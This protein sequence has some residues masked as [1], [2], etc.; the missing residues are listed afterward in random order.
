MF[1]SEAVLT[2]SFTDSGALGTFIQRV[3]NEI[4]RASDKDV[5]A[6]KM[7][8]V[9]ALRHFQPL[10]LWFRDATGTFELTADT[11]S[12]GEAT[13]TVDGYPSDL[14]RPITMWVQENGSEN[15]TELTQVTIS[16]IRAWVTTD[17]VTGTP[18]VWAWHDEYIW[19]AP[20]PDSADTIRIDY[21]SNT[22]IPGYAWSGSEWV[23]YGPSGQPLTDRWTSPWFT[24]GEE[25]LRARVKWDLYFN[26]YD[27]SENAFKQGGV[28]GDGGAVAMALDRLLREQGRKHYN[29]HRRAIEV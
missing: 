11:Q 26:Y 3:I 22:G 21:V 27:D 5:E 12:Y 15:W 2:T 28:D 14:V 16:D 4:A 29:V 17:T 9:S 18:S 25:A 10:R 13:S 1:T 6:V 23:F 24:K 8:T 7:A 20:I 19:F